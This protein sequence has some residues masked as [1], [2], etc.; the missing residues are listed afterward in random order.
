M[1]LRLLNK[2]RLFFI[3]MI[4]VAVFNTAYATNVSSVT[5]IDMDRIQL[6]SQQIALLKMKLA[7]VKRLKQLQTK[8]D[9]GY[10]NCP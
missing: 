6:V 2:L 10:H 5:E 1:R 9:E 8:Q 4:S 3:L 7:Q